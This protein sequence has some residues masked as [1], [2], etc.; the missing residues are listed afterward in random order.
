[1]TSRP[2]ARPCSTMY[3]KCSLSSGAPPVMSKVVTVGLFLIICH[4]WKRGWVHR[5][6]M[7]P[8]KSRQTKQKNLRLV[9]SRMKTIVYGI[10]TFPPRLSLVDWA[11]GRR[12]SASH[13][14]PTTP[15]DVST[16][17]MR[18]SWPFRARSSAAWFMSIPRRFIMG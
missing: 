17:C 7:H 10:A 11:A 5:H 16:P 6:R 12:R 9:H 18:A 4:Q 14:E 2:S 8:A 3:R 13:A 1:M 15:V